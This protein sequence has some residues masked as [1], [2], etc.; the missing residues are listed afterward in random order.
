MSSVKSLFLEY[1]TL[2]YYPGQKPKQTKDINIKPY[3]ILRTSPTGWNILNLWNGT[4]IF[5]PWSLIDLFTGLHVWGGGR[6][7]RKEAD[8]KIEKFI[9]QF[10]TLIGTAEKRDMKNFFIALG[11]ILNM[12]TKNFRE[13]YLEETGEKLSPIEINSLDRYRDL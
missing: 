13:W 8:D 1:H 12:G 6:I 2:S 7:L 10:L 5:I 4:S 9:L 11:E 3:M